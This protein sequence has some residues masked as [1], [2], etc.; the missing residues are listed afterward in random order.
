[1]GAQIICH[2][3]RFPYDS[4]KPRCTECGDPT[5]INQMWVDQ[6]GKAPAISNR[7]WRWG[8]VLALALWLIFAG[9]IVYLTADG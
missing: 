5:I 6:G 1:M 7:A 4:E 3:C 2:G 9:V 8:T